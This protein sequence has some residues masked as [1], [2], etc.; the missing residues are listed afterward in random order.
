MP[1]NKEVASEGVRLELG[2][3][4]HAHAGCWID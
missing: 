2:R 4:Y 1:R 3:E